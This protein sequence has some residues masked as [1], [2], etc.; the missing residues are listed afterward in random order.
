MRPVKPTENLNTVW[1]TGEHLYV[2]C[3]KCKRRKEIELRGRRGNMQPIN[4]LKLRCAVCGSD[5][6]AR[7]LPKGGEDRRAWLN[8]KG[9][10]A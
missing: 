5:D 4:S 3:Q 8:E 7:F 6:I 1:F 10:P 2:E 9:P